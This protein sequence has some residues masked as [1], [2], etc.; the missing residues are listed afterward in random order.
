M[1]FCI[2]GGIDSYEI[3]AEYFKSGAEKVSLN[4]YAYINK[5]LIKSISESYGNQSI[6]ASIDIKKNIFGKYRAFIY[7]GTKKIDLD[8]IELAQ[9]YQEQGAGEIL[10]SSIDRDGTYKGYDIELINKLSKHISIPLIVAGGCGNLGHMKEAIENGADS[11]A[12][13]SVFVFHSSTKGVL[14]NYPT[15]EELEELFKN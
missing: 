3:A 9:I 14:I 6:V 11:A 5:D 13:G 12:A 8:P 4:S 7:S 10:L 2:G 1:P 15:K